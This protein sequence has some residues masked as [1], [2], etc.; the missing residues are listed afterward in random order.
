M[1]KH[2]TGAH[3]RK[4]YAS[5]HASLCV[6]GSYLRLIGFFRSPES[7]C[8]PILLQGESGDR[9]E[10]TVKIEQKVLKYTPVQ[11][12]EMLFVAIL[13]G[14]KTVYHTGTTLRVD[15]ALQVRAYAFWQQLPVSKATA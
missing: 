15:R 2:N 9:I 12:I 14:A 6:L 3:Q 4:W 5:S 1:G 7:P 11:K 13:A 8:S 10:E